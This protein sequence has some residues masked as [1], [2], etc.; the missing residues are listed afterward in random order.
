MSEGD[1]HL[2]DEGRERVPCGLLKR[3]TTCWMNEG[4]K[5]L[6]M[7][8]RRKHSTWWMSGKTDYRGK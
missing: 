1:E 3:S 7:S 4:Q 2:V 6:V 5:Y 8:K